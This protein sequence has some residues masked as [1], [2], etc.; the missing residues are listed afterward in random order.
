MKACL[1]GYPIDPQLFNHIQIHL[2]AHPHFINSAINAYPKRSG[3]FEAGSGVS[4]VPVPADLATE[5]AVIETESRQLS[6]GKTGLLDPVDIIS[7]P[8][9]GLAIDGREQF[10]FLLSNEVMREL[11]TGKHTPGEEEVTTAI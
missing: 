7:D 9:K 10:I 2:T 1:F 8:N 6:S 4:T 3:L 5:T 11:L